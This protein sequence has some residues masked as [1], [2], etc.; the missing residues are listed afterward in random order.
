M[1]DKATLWNLFIQQQGVPAKWKF[2]F[3]YKFRNLL[4]AIILEKQNTF[5]SILNFC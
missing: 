4:S 2:E 1:A 3:G 5:V